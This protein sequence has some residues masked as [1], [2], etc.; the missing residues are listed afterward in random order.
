MVHSV[1]DREKKLTVTDCGAVSGSRSRAPFPSGILLEA[2][3]QEVPGRD[4]NR[5][6]LSPRAVAGVPPAPAQVQGNEV[7]AEAPHYGQP[8]A[9][10]A[11]VPPPHNPGRSGKSDY[12]E[13]REPPTTLSLPRAKMPRG[14]K[15]RRSSR[16]ATGSYSRGG[17]IASTTATD[18]KC[19]RNLSS[20]VVPRVGF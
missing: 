17:T 12:S 9:L 15:R 1:S 6:S 11:G 14:G 7:V 2:L 13:S 4:K 19:R 20:L 3:C 16:I 5:T 18:L 8:L 10:V